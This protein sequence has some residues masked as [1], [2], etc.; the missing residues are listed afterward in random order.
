MQITWEV[1]R[2]NEENKAIKVTTLHLLVY[3]GVNCADYMRS[4]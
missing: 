1:D 2:K 4:R 3:T